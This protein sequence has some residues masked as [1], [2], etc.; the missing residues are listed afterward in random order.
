RAEQARN[1]YQ[2]GRDQIA[3]IR[4][5]TTGGWGTN[6]GEIVSALFT[7]TRSTISSCYFGDLIIIEVICSYAE[8]IQYPCLSFLVQ[9]ANLVGIGGRWFRLDKPIEPG[10]TVTLRVHFPAKFNPG[11]YFITLRLEDRKDPKQSFVLHK[12]PGVLS[13]HMFDDGPESLLGFRDLE[14]ERDT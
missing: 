12:L 11:R 3:P 4:E 1:I 9:S 10:G 6:E 13:F 14:I 2:K 7:E 5:K 8:S